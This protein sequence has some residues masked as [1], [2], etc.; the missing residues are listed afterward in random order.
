M[1]NGFACKR[2]LTLFAVPTIC[3]NPFVLLQFSSL[4]E[5]FISHFFVFVGKC[6]HCPGHLHGLFS[7]VLQLFPRVSQTVLQQLILVAQVYDLLV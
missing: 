3:G 2:I 4:I 1:P 5:E 7:L 6:C